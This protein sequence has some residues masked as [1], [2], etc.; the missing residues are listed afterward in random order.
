[1]KGVGKFDVIGKNIPMHHLGKN[2]KI[3]KKTM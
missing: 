2:D 1:M 3:K